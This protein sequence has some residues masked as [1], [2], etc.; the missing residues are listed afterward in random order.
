MTF[1]SLTLLNTL[2]PNERDTAPSA[3]YAA[4]CV[5]VPGGAVT[6]LDVPAEGAQ[7]AASTSCRASASGPV[8]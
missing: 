4:R 7:G 5:S 1:P 6:A 2:A 3:R 8:S